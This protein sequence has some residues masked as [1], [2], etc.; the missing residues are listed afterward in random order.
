MCWFSLRTVPK[1]EK[2]LK[3]GFAEL[4]EAIITLKKEPNGPL[5]KCL[6]SGNI[7]K[8]RESLSEKLNDVD[9]IQLELMIRAVDLIRN[10]TTEFK[11]DVIQE[12]LHTRIIWEEPATQEFSNTTSPSCSNA[13]T[14]NFQTNLSNIHADYD[15]RMRNIRDGLEKIVPT[16]KWQSSDS[17]LS[18]PSTPN[19]NTQ[20]SNDDTEWERENHGYDPEDFA[21]EL[22]QEQFNEKL[23]NS[24]L[25]GIKL[26]IQKA[27]EQEENLRK[28]N[29]EF[30]QKLSKIS[31]ETR[32]KNLDGK[33]DRAEYEKETERLRQER[34]SEWEATTAAF[35][36]CVHLK[37]HFVKEEDSWSAWLED[38]KDE[39]S[40]AKTRFSQFETLIS[41]KKYEMMIV[42]ETEI[43]MEQL[44]ILHNLTYNAYD[45][46]YEAWL[47]VRTLCEKFPTRIFLFILQKYL[48][49][50]C[51]KLCDVMRSIDE[52][53]NTPVTLQHIRESFGQLH[54]FNIPST[55]QLK[56]E[57]LE[58]EWDDYCNIGKPAVYRSDA[59]VVQIEEL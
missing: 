7:N 52:F 14:R 21:P 48:V 28:N 12:P 4:Q 45:R 1:W 36:Q 35:I 34:I 11:N 41:F 50:V 2:K 26:E 53:H 37:H 39:I 42:E 13:T 57:S 17:P 5:R 10:S 54:V 8:L 6:E 46:V 24:L 47:D 44:P 16:K 3:K 43:L 49:T 55:W 30:K 19:W 29:L 32:Q 27:N 15:K 56:N 58:A 59:S 20:E 31:E 23:G 18:S 25:N 33:R 51:D 22:S 9:V 40:T 38:M